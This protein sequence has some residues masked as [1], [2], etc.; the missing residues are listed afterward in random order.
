MLG[1]VAVPDAGAEE[2]DIAGSDL[3][4]AGQRPVDRLAAGDDRDLDEAVRVV[5]H[6]RFVD[7]V[8]GIGE[9][10]VGEE[11]PAPGHRHRHLTHGPT[12]PRRHPEDDFVLPA[13]HQRLSAGAAWT[14]HPA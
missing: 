8:A 7:P 10:A 13:G 12:L 4:T 5:L 11:R 9:R 1:L 2:H 3:T 6:R 14:D